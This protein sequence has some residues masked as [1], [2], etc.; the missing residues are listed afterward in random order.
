[1]LHFERE[2]IEAEL[3]EEMLRQFKHVNLGLQ[4]TDGY[5]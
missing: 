3:I 1:M 5:P 2:V 4:D